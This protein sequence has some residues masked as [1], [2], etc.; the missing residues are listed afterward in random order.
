MKPE[1]NVKA[2]YGGTLIHAQRDRYGLVEIVAH[3]DERSLHFGSSIE[4]A[5]IRKGAPDPLFHYARWLT[6]T[7]ALRH[8]A[9]TALLLGLGAGSVARSLWQ[10][11]ATLQLDAVEL[12]EA[13]VEAAYTW[14]ELPIDS[15]LEVYVADAGHFVTVM[16]RQ[17]DLLIVDLYDARGEIEL[18]LERDFLCACR[19]RLAPGGVLGINLWRVSPQRFERSLT[20]LRSVFDSQLLC[21]DA[22]EAN[23][24]VF[25]FKGR[26]PTPEALARRARVRRWAS[27]L[28]L[29]IGGLL[30]SYAIK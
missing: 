4:Q 13:V 27:A 3:D 25:A 29:D 30:Q 18:L 1:S 23:T 22:D 24:V 19:D 2:R 5:R 6:F 28:D 12:R 8:R 15:R 21:V 16:D 26:R 20:L 9:D 11:S 17:Y 10:R 7:A 14:F